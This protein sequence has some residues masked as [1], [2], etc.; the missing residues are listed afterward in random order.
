MDCPRPS[1]GPSAVQ[2][3]RP[4]RTNYLSGQI[5]IYT[6]DRPAP[7]GGPSAVHSSNPPETTTSLDKILDSTADCLALLG[8][9]STVHPCEPHQKISSL[10]KLRSLRQ[11]VRSPIAD[12]PLYNLRNH[13]RQHRLWTTSNL[14]CGLSGPPRRTVRDSLLQTTRH[15]AV[16]T[17]AAATAV[18][19]RRRRTTGGGKRPGGQSDS[20]RFH[21]RGRFER[22]ITGEAD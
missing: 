16:S 22:R 21:S 7:L 3:C 20:P 15:A 8:G 12:R 6:A 14:T 1:G 10:D 9:P 17:A 2:L 19:R 18:H 13:Q 11:T 5:S 4:T